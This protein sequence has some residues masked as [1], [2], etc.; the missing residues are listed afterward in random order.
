MEGDIHRP[1]GGLAFAETPVD[2]G[3]AVPE[4]EVLEELLMEEREEYDPVLE[5]EGA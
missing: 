4:R 1:D 3:V 5:L 2:M